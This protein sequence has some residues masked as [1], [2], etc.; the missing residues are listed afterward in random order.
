MPPLMTRDEQG[1]FAANLKRLKDE[2]GATW[3][4][5]GRACGHSNGR[6]VQRLAEGDFEPRLVTVYSVAR[7][8]GVNATELVGDATPT[9]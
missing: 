4:D 3:D 5:I 6:Y 2:R 8:F 9:E 7:Y 1:R